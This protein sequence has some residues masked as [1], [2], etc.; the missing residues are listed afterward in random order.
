ML[1]LLLATRVAL[2]RRRFTLVITIAAFLFFFSNFFF[3]NF[4]FF[5]VCFRRRH[6]LLVLDFLRRSRGLYFRHVFRCSVFTHFAFDIR[7]PRSSSLFPL[8]SSLFPLLL[9]YPTAAMASRL[10]SFLS[11]S[12]FFSLSSLFF[13]LLMKVPVVTSYR[14]RERGHPSDRFSILRPFL[15][16]RS[17]PKNNKKRTFQKEKKK[18]REVSFSEKTRSL[19]A[20]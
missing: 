2:S 20:S 13:A 14:I 10:V 18:E 4:S 15:F 19:G 1:L 12:L 17:H 8:P 16:F 3:F 9:L 6:R 7:G 5:F 11:L